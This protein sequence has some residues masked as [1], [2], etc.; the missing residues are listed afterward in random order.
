MFMHVP[1]YFA[2]C[3]KPAT[4]GGKEFEEYLEIRDAVEKIRELQKGKNV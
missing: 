1:L 3:S 2:E 4:G